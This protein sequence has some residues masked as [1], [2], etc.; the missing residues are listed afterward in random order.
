MITD[1]FLE[2]HSFDKFFRSDKKDKRTIWRTQHTVDLIDSNIAVFGCFPGREGGL[3]MKP[4]AR[5]AFSEII[6]DTVLIFRG[7]TIAFHKQ[8]TSALLVKAMQ[9]FFVRMCLI[10][11]PVMHTGRNTGGFSHQG[12]YTRCI[13]TIWL[14]STRTD[15]LYGVKL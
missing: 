8:K 7:V 1:V 10:G 5:K 11:Q 14:F 13:S 9:T 3:Q 15:V 12:V 2:F 4:C 6:K